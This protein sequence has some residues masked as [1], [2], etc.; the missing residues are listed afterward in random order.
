MSYL[1]LKTDAA[2][3]L[4]RAVA[5]FH[6]LY[7]NDSEDDA[8][9][10]RNA[11][12][13]PDGDIVALP[14]NKNLLVEILRNFYVARLVKRALLIMDA[15]IEVSA[16]LDVTPIPGL[17]REASIYYLY[18][19]RRMEDLTREY[20]LKVKNFLAER[21]VTYLLSCVPSK[22]MTNHKIKATGN[23]C[24]QAREWALENNVA[25]V[26][27]TEKFYSADKPLFF[28]RDI[29]FNE[30]GHEI[31]AQTLA[32]RLATGLGGRAIEIDSQD[33]AQRE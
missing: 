2:E 12:F 15:M 24:S 23:F 21:E 11:V 32:N 7:S 19:D 27:L 13:G 6:L 33:G 3:D 25:Y 31:V 14:G 8:R 20:L 22:L 4:E 5:V 28:E 30:A 26:D 10:I 1:Q 16:R 9:Y 18:E 17:D 29:H